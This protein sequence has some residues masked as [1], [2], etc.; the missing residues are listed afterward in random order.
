MDS[1]LLLSRIEKERAFHNK[2]FAERG[3]EKIDSVYLT[4]NRSTRFYEKLIVEGAEHNHVLEYGCGP[5]SYA[6]YMARHGSTVQGID[7]SDEAIEQMRERSKHRPFPERVSFRRMN[8]EV[9]EFPDNEFDLVTGRA[10]LHH[11]DLR[12]SFKEI[13]RT[14]KPTGK[15]VFVEPLG[16]NPII[17]YFRNRTPEMR[18]EDEHPLLINDLIMAKEYFGKVDVHYY[19]LA[20]LAA[21][22]FAGMKIFDSVLKM[23]DALDRVIFDTLP[24]ARKHAWA[25]VL[26]FSDPKS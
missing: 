20:G 6:F 13:S 12:A 2:E 16:H 5:H 18:T 26:A 21:T 3:R 10:I 15:A 4:T 8:A 23:L 14:L 25:V 7:I 22:P 9:L 19:H 17:N 11:L 1:N 24:F